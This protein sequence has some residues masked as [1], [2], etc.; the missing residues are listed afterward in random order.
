M[1]INDIIEFTKCFSNESRLKIIKLL[2]EKE[3][4]VCELEAITGQTQS[5]ISQ[6]LRILFQAGLVEKRRD[7]QWIYYKLNHESF[8]ENLKGI[9]EFVTSSLIELPDLQEELLRFQSLEQN[10]LVR[11]CKGLC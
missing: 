2:A 4:C 7:G 8:R 9:E 1:K 6:H 11:K 10:E 5:S 3:L